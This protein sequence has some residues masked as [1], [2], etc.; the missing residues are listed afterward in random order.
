[1]VKILCTIGPACDSEAVLSAM[2]DAGM[3]MARFNLSHT[4]G[5]VPRST[6]GFIPST[7]ARVLIIHSWSSG[8][9]GARV[10]PQLP[11]MTVVIPCQE[12][13]VASGSQSS[14]AS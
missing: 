5:M 4:Q 6:S 10:N 1:M 3:G 8:R 2:V 7:R 13:D 12:D 11:V 9:Q 14:W